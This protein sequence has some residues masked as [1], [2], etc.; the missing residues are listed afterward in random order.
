[1]LL[2]SMHILLP[3]GDPAQLRIFARYFGFIERHFKC[4]RSHHPALTDA[5]MTVANRSRAAN[6]LIDL[7]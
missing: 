3:I 7:S 5:I 2:C 4:S 6:V 1:M